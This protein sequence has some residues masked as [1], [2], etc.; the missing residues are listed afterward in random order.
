MNL[1]AGTRLLA[2]SIAAGA[3]ALATAGAAQAA[4][5]LSPAGPYATGASVTVSGVAPA[6]SPSAATHYAI[7]ECN[8]TSTNPAT[9]AQRCNGNT[10]TFTAL[11][12]LSGGTSYHGT[13]AVERDYDDVDFSGATTPTTSTICKTFGSDQ[14]SVLVSF[15]RVTG[16]IP[17]FLGIDYQT[18]SV[19]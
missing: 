7:A 4:P 10:G 2:A 19:F 9:W 15:Y 14:C 1:R 13:I 16:G 3:L 5:T 11:T 8:T 18:I 12:A 6:F 17:S